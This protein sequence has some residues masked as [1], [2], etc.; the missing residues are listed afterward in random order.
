MIVMLGHSEMDMEV[1][2]AGLEIVKS[3]NYR[4][5]SKD[6][7]NT[8][9]MLAIT[10][11]RARFSH[12]DKWKFIDPFAQSISGLF[13]VSQLYPKDQRAGRIKWSNI[14]VQIHTIT[15]GENYRKVSNFGNG[16]V[17]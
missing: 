17:L 10:Q 9:S 12:K 5:V 6:D 16:A 14:E 2:D 11:E 8:N 7:R 1:S 13:W 4:E 15:Y 3:D